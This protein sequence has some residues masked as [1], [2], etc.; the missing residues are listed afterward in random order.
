MNVEVR[1]RRRTPWW[2]RAGF[3]CVLAV[4]GVP[5]LGLGLVLPIA[6][7]GQPPARMPYAVPAKHAVFLSTTSHATECTVSEGGVEAL[8]VSIAEAQPLPFTGY[9]LAPRT[10][11]AATVSCTRPTMVTVDPDWRYTLADSQAAKLTLTVV[12]VFALVYISA[13]TRHR[14][15]RRIRWFLRGG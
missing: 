2:Q 15:W 5:A 14:F 1:R 7:S 11:G 3:L 6:L 8:H 4:V 12:G 9:R 10:S 13:R